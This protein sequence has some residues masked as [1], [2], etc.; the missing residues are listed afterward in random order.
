MNSTIHAKTITR[1]LPVI[2]S[3]LLIIGAPHKAQAVSPPPDG[4][5]PNF[6]TAEGDNALFHLTTGSGNTAVGWFSLFSNAEGSFNTATGAGALLFNTADGNAAFGAAALLFNTT[7]FENTAIGAA[8]LLNNTEGSFNTAIGFRAL[9]SNTTGGSNTA[10]GEI[11][12]FSNTT[13]SGNTANGRDTLFDNTEGNFNTANGFQALANNTTGNANTANGHNALLNNT[14][15]TNNTAI[16]A[17]AL[18]NNTTGGSNTALGAGA[19][20]GVTV[21]NNVIAIG[22]SGANVDNSCFINN[23]R[24]VTTSTTGAIPVLI[25]PA[26]QLGTMSSSRRFKKEIQPMDQV[27]EAILALKPVT[28]HYKSDN[29]NRPEFGLIAEEV[30]EVDPNLVVRDDNGDIYTVRY[31]AVN[32]MLLNEFLKEHRKVEEQKATITQLKSTV[33]KQEAA[34]AQQ[35]KDF[36]TTITE[37][38]IRMETVVTRLK[39]HDSKI[40]RVSDQIEISTPAPRVVLNNPYHHPCASHR[41]AATDLKR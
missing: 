30:A 1:V 39:E 20:S 41:E 11:A 15:G 25:D 32:A 22:I 5:Y 24:G 29:T 19:G 16:G 18:E 23:I 8:A 13:G 37:L 7:G 10:N 12:L 4:G 2:A 27:S 14:T 17:S 33:A 35:R 31:D 40:E 38:K 28:F 3:T 34:I 6:T 21:S 36:E 26:G 9:E